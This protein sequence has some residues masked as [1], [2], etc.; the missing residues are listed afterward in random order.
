MVTVL[1]ILHV[2]FCLLLIL[3]IL[4]QSGKGSDV[5]SMLG[6]GASQTLFGPAGGKNIMVRI[7][8][9]VAILILITTM[10]LAKL[11]KT[12]GPSQ[13]KIIA[14]LQ[15]E[16]AATQDANPLAKA[17]KN[18]T[19]EAKAALKPEKKPAASVPLKTVTPEKKK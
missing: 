10:V 14:D 7:T 15:K 13:N 12:Y 2:I 5:G 16:A 19:P 8:T 6:G 1:T 17:G 4:L 3:L 18:V 11:P 9:V